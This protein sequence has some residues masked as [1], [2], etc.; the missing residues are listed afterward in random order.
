MLLKRKLI[1]YNYKFI[2]TKESRYNWCISC[3]LQY[4]CRQIKVDDY[5]S[6]F[7]LCENLARR[8]LLNCRNYIY[9]L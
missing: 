5:S 3:R 6:L 2:R 9:V 4:R 7:K 8:F 1:K